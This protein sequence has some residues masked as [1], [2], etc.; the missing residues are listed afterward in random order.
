MGALEEVTGSLQAITI[1]RMRVVPACI[2]MFFHFQKG[3]L[4]AL[5]MQ[6]RAAFTLI[7]LLV[8]IAIIAI[9]IGLLVP[10]VQKVR[11]A[12][13][14]TQTINN[15]KQIGLATQNM[16]GTYNTKMPM[17]GYFGVRYTSV[18]GHLLPYVEQGNIYNLITNAPNAAVAPAITATNASNGLGAVQYTAAVIP[19]YQAPSDAT[20]GAST[21][22]SILIAGYGIT[23]FA[24]NGNLFNPSPGSNSV[25]QAFANPQPAPAAAP[26]FPATFGSA[27]T[28]NVVMFATHYATCGSVDQ[29]WSSPSTYFTNSVSPFIPQVAPGLSGTANATPPGNC[30]QYFVQGFNAAGAQVGMGDGS[31]RTCT[32]AVS[33]AT[34]VIVTNP[35]STSPPGSDWLQ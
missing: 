31:V 8:V 7:E 6:K 17:N 25:P 13:A 2:F 26:R 32:P 30:A 12:A 14:R 28:S 33:S 15:L 34:W 9:L 4:M 19:S 24:S 23:S 11:E 5:R 29:I 3:C 18:F 10:A 20:Q 21:G 27:G 22:Q 16:A 35:Q 1:G